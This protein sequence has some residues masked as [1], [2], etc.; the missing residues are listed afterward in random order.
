MYEIQNIVKDV[1]RDILQ[2]A[3]GAGKN[4]AHI[5]PS[6]SMAEMLTVLFAD[7]FNYDNDR[8][9]LSK[10]H[11]GLGY[12]AVMHAVGRI[13]KEQL[14]TFE[15]DGGD[16]PGQPCRQTGNGILYSSGSLGL[17]LS[18]G[19]G[20]AWAMKLQGKMG[21]VVVVMG[22]GELNEG[23]VWEAAMLAK[24]Q[25]LSNLLVVVDWN[26]MQSDGCSKDII[27]MDLIN[28]WKSFG[29]EVT[30][31][32]GHDI[33]ELQEAYHM[34]RQN[35]PRVILAKTVKGKGVSFMEG[36]RKWHHSCLDK[37]QYRIAL[38]EL[39]EINGV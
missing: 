23:C 32:N 14:D 30:V 29:W 38:K 3:Y 1:R 27:S 16:F 7:Y 24:Q 25:C 39:E 36:E 17:G 13:S 21:K 19:V 37:E 15:M 12:Y 9:I 35:A 33:T 34:G 10:G 28:I 4:G 22:D 18:Y 6:L 31:C 2:L 8:F 5:G 20:H 11:G 26:G